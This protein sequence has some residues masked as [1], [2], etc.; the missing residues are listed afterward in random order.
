[1]VPEPKEDWYVEGTVEGKSGTGW[2]IKFPVFGEECVKAA[3]YFDEYALF[4]LP[5]TKKLVT[6]K[7]K[8]YV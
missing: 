7:S 4:D 3:S 1:M 5:K 2:L 6:K 8:V